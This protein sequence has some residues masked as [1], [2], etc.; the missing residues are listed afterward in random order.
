MRVPRKP[1]RK[2]SVIMP[3]YNEEETVEQMLDAVLDAPLPDGVE[4]EVV[5]VESNSADD[6]RKIVQQYETDPRVRLYFQEVARGKGNALHEGFRRATGDVIL[7]QDGDLEYTPKDYPALLEPIVTGETDFVLGSR[8]VKGEPIRLIEEA[9]LLSRIMNM[10]HWILC[11]LFNVTYRIWLRDPFTMYKVF[12]RECI[13]GIEWSANRFDFDWELMAKLVRRGYRPIE[14]PVAYQARGYHNGKKIRPFRDPP[15]WIAACFRFR[16][17]HVP[18]PVLEPINTRGWRRARRKAAQTV[19]H[20]GIDP[21]AAI[22]AE[23]P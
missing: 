5:I 6:T 14:V 18:P 3:V 22:E 13:E 11:T 17:V 19:E 12:R 2:L 15:T 9:R 7:I 8:H 23:S 21:S 1:I 4:M 10:A 16:F 20:P